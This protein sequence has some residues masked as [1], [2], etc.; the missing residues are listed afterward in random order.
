MEL[1]T[2]FILAVISWSHYLL[3]PVGGRPTK[4]TD[5]PIQS[6]SQTEKSATHEKDRESAAIDGQGRPSF[7]SHRQRRR[8]VLP[9]P[10]PSKSS[11]FGVSVDGYK[12]AFRPTTPGNS[13]SAGHSFGENDEETE[14]KPA[15][16]VR[17]IDGKHSINDDIGGF[18]PTTPGHNPEGGHAFVSKK[19]EPNG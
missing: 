7:A 1:R 19:S 6:S 4:S 2:V 11:D 8:Q 10:M 13:P 15:G 9:P 3:F 12:D 18:R 16:R 14:Q 5:G 17:S